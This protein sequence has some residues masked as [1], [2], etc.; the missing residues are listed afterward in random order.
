VQAA[1]ALTQAGEA[2]RKAR[3]ILARLRAAVRGE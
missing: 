1:D 3:G 2:A